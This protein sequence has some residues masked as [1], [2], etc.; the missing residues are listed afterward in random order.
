[1]I[2][3]MDVGHAVCDYSAYFFQAFVRS[4]TRDGIPLHQDVGLCEEFQRFESCAV[5]TENSLA[6]LDEALFIP[7]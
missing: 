7:H 5:R 3:G 1:M 4:H 6:A 2:Y